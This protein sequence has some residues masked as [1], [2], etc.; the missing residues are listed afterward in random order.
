MTKRQL[1]LEDGTTFIGNAF[2]SNVS[3]HGEVI[4][5]TGM[6]GYQELISDPSY[7][8]KIV[9]MTYPS[10]GTY[11]INRNDFESI[12]P[13]IRGMVVKEICHEPSNFQ[14]EE[15][16]DHFLRKHEIPGIAGIDT[17]M[18]TR[19]LRQK[20]TQKGI[21][22]N[23]EVNRNEVI[24][25]LQSTKINESVTEI[26]TTRPYV[27]PGSGKR[28]VVIDFGVKH[29]I[30]QALSERNCHITVVPY[31]FKKEEILRFKPD[32][33]ILSHGPGNPADLEQ[34]V[35]TINKLLGIP[36]LGIGLGHQLFARACGS[37]TC[38]M[39]VGRYGVN[40]PVKDYKTDKTWI[41]TQSSHYAIAESTLRETN[42]KIT[43]RSIDNGIVEGLEHSI[44]PAISVQFNLE[45]APGSNETSFILTQFLQMTE[46]DQI[47]TN[48]GQEHA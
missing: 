13:L 42:L 37:T 44:Y 20:G 40:F 47:S 17:R 19:L 5:Y 8:G 9:T 21:I 43:H 16:L 27:I 46:F 26:S 6:T 22:T 31:H 30:L 38:K 45:G 32:G 25:Q 2:G 18:L 33:I 34:T 12:T 4:F 29:R 48:G 35:A 1:I 14:S 28:I 36:L 24:Q 11:G 23:L 3:K 7:Y 15:T 41:T 10:I 39:R